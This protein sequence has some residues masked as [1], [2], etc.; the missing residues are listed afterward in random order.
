MRLRRVAWA[1]CLAPLFSGGCN[2]AYYTARNITN[3]PVQACENVSRTYHL[4][5]EAKAAW[6]EV[7]EQFPRKCFTAE[8]RD[9]F[10][11]GYVDYL[12]RGGNA[13]PPVVAPRR[14]ARNDYL[15]PEGHLLIKDYFL[16]F[17]YGLDVAVASGKRQFLVV[18]VLVPERQ[19]GPTAF[20]LQPR[21]AADPDAPPPAPL[22][23]PRTVPPDAPPVPAATAVPTPMP[24]RVPMPAVPAAPPLTVPAP[25][26]VVPPAGPQGLAPAPTRWNATAGQ[27]NTPRTPTPAV[28]V[29]RLT[30]APKPTPTP[31][32]PFP[33]EPPGV[34][35]FGSPL[36]PEA[37]TADRLPRP[38][39]PLP[40]PAPRPL[41]AADGPAGGTPVGAM[42][43]R[44]PDPPA[45]VPDLPPHVPTPSILDDLPD[46][47][48]NHL[49]P[50]PKPVRL[51]G[52]KGK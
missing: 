26:P 23:P 37:E 42:P 33:G 30:S 28:A 29:P 43:F 4:R 13:Q 2:I 10:L 46:L 51:D 22:P 14:Y 9:G 15:T 27:P 48:A 8:F 7:R 45:E 11:D 52:P 41:G 47:P 12:D 49:I 17:R 44:L 40:L 34:S 32:A 3:E 20:N 31:A 25:Q 18:P 35:K 5:K 1:C 24:P 36:P 19:A 38:N 16:G 50:P 6:A 39:P 21:G